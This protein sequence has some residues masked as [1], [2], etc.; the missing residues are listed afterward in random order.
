M[1]DRRIYDRASAVPAEEIDVSDAA[2][3]QFPS[4]ASRPSHN[5]SQL[6]AVTRARA[7]IMLKGNQSRRRLVYCIPANGEP[8]PSI[9]ATAA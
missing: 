3:Q 5:S 4:R 7:V 6:H 8:Q 1:S 9:Q 2:L